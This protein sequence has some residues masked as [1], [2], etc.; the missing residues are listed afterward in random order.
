MITKMNIG[1]QHAR[2]MNSPVLCHFRSPLENDSTYQSLWAVLENNSSIE[3][4]IGY[5][6]HIHLYQYTISP[7]HS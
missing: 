3:K 5:K 6:N 4:L 7:L 1:M 2:N